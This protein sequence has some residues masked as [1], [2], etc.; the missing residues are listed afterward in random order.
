M[1]SCTTIS[2]A[3]WNTQPAN[4]VIEYEEVVGYHLEQ[5]YPLQG[6]ARHPSTKPTRA[7]ARD[8]AERLGS[9]GRRAFGRSDAH[10]GCQT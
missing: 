10:R 8:A 9:A 2:A 6:R 5:A 4:R 3:G 7:I 1:L